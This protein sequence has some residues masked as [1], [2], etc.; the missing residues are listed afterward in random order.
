MPL[1]LIRERGE[2]AKLLVREARAR[3]GRRGEDAEDPSPAL[4]A[5][6]HRL[7][8]LGHALIVSPA[9]KRDGHVG[10]DVRGEI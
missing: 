10:P 7:I 6:R 5:P 1:H 4:R 3:P 8:L 2:E 9:G